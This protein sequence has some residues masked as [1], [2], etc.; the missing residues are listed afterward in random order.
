MLSATSYGLDKNYMLSQI[1]KL[2]NLITCICPQF[3]QSTNF[4]LTKLHLIPYIFHHI[5]RSKVGAMKYNHIRWGC[6]GQ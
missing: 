5:G 6:V 3:L 2:P 1:R 4:H